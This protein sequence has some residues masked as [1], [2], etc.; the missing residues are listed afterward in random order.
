MSSLM[1]SYSKSEDEFDDA[2]SQGSM[3]IHE[4]VDNTENA[5]NE[6]MD[7]GDD[8]LDDLQLM[9]DGMMTDEDGTDVHKKKEY[10]NKMKQFVPVINTKDVESI[11][12]A[13]QIQNFRGKEEKTPKKSKRRKSKKAKRL[14]QTSPRKVH[15]PVVFIIHREHCIHRMINRY[16]DQNWIMRTAEAR[17]MDARVN[18]RE[19]IIQ[20][21]ANAVAIDPLLLHK[22]DDLRAMKDAKANKNEDQNHANERANAGIRSNTVTVAVDRM[23]AQDHRMIITTIHTAAVII[24]TH[25]KRKTIKRL[26]HSTCKIQCFIRNSIHNTLK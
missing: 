5:I 14:H 8:I 9:D 26:R 19:D 23:M 18:P 15:S 16:S 10:T 6:S 3:L 22:D 25:N 12:I 4:Q 7:I 2:A 20:S 21:R 1:S 13:K 17:P 11:E 24:Q